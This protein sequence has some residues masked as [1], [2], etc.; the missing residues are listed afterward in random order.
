VTGRA[1]RYSI[2]LID[3]GT[4]QHAAAHAAATNFSVMRV[5]RDILRRSSIGLVAT[6]RSTAQSGA[7]SNQAYGVDGTFAFFANVS[8]N[9]YWAKTRTTGIGGK[10]TSYRTQLE[11]AGDRYGVQLDRIVVGEHFNPE[12]GFVRRGNIRESYGQFRFSPR[13]KASKRVRKYS[14]IGTITYV[15][16]GAGRLQTRTTDGEAAIELQS[17]D[18]FSVGATGNFERLLLPFA[19]APTVGI[20]VGEYDFSTARVGYVF[21]QQRPVS[22]TL[23]AERGSFYNGRR[24]SVSFTKT[25][26]NPTARFSLEPTV[27]LNWIDLPN[28]SFMTN[29]LGSRVTYTMTPQ[30]FVSALLQYNT[31]TNRVSTN[32]RLRW[33]YRP[34]SEL[35]VVYNEERDTLTPRFP[36]LQNRAFIVKANRLLRF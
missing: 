5:K 23:L 27:S 29:L 20:A 11:Y 24:N 10:D 15:E 6:S 36:G 12:V 33:E 28:G 3:I 2:G 7:G 32:M 21:G 19:I 4:R 13:P 16:D 25:R 31:S 8:V 14:G 30:M 9:T 26:V 18:R 35:F 17:S 1:G 34:G 22:G